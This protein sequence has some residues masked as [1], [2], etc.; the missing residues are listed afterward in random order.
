MESVWLKTKRSKSHN[1]LLAKVQKNLFFKSNNWILCERSIKSSTKS[2]ILKNRFLLNYNYFDLPKSVKIKLKGKT[3][4][5]K[6]LTRYFITFKCGVTHPVA[7]WLS[8]ATLFKKKSKQKFRIFGYSLSYLLNCSRKLTSWKRY[9][10]YHWRGILLCR[11]R[12]YRKKGIV[13]TYM[14]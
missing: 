13:S 8:Y 10:I 3:L 1:L 9:N 4:K 5:F 12:R 6:R 11:T 7:S 14:K 2:L